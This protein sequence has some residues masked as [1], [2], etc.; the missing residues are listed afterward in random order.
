MLSR[1]ICAFSPLKNWLVRGSEDAL[2][3]FS[4]KP[5]KGE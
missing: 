2:D 4:R 5:L 1:S 3:F